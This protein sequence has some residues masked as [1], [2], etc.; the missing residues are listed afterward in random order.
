MIAIIHTIVRSV[1]N[2]IL[3]DCFN[4]KILSNPYATTLVAVLHTEDIHVLCVF[5]AHDTLRRFS[6]SAYYVYSYEKR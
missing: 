2:I 4:K 1:V 3:T 5:R 6:D